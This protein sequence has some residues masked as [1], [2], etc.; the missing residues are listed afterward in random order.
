MRYQVYLGLIAVLFKAAS[1]APQEYQALGVLQPEA[2][3][4]GP[5]DRMISATIDVLPEM[6]D[7]FEEIADDPRH[8]ND[9]QRIQKVI[10]VFMPL[11]RRL[12]LA[13]AEVEGRQWAKE[14]QYRFN[15]AGAVLPSVF[16]FMDRLRN[17][18]F[19]GSGTR[20]VV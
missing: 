17:K 2:G 16:S 19:F 12:I 3:D 18:D 15:A 9:P 1:S 7:V 6:A 14:D 13:N 5:Y 11:T 4:V 10:N 8:P 20:N